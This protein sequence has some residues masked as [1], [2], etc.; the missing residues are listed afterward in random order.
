[1]L[2]EE[3]VKDQTDHYRSLMINRQ[4]IDVENIALEDN[5]LE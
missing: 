4:H 1:M 5:R 2:N 3:V